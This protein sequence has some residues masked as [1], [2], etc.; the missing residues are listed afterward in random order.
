MSPTSARRGCHPV[1]DTILAGLERQSLVSLAAEKNDLTVVS[2][3]GTLPVLD[4]DVFDNSA[5][6]SLSNLP[7]SQ[8]GSTLLGVVVDDIIYRLLNGL[9]KPT[10][11]L[12][13]PRFST[14]TGRMAPDLSPTIDPT[15]NTC[16]LLKRRFV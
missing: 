7:S 16:V 5:H 6:N 11:P 1:V 15:W 13:S 10:S 3:G 9:S 14:A 8:T 12:D 2:G 4:E